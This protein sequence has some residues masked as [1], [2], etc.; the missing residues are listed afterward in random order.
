M[1]MKR[2]KSIKTRVFTVLLLTQIPLIIIII[3]YNFYFVNYFNQSIS[4]SN[5]N[6]LTSYCDILQDD[7]E[8][9]N[10]GLLNYVASDV[11]FKMLST[12]TRYLDA[13]IHSLE[14]IN[15]FHSL[16]EDNRILYGCYII[17]N[18]YQ[19][20]RECY[21]SQ[22]SNYTMN[23]KLRSYFSFYLKQN[24]SIC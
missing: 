15:Y 24:G 22:K 6:A 7:L 3:V 20:F 18:R 17:N 12:D 10:N 5:K 23:E 19:I 2:R 4:K 8:R 1:E 13:H 14:I 9:I 21:A 11:Y 16:L